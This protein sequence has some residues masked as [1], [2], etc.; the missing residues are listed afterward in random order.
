MTQPATS[1]VLLYT[2]ALFIAGAICGAATMYHLTPAA[3]PLKLGRINEIAAKLRTRLDSRLQLT[4]EQQQKF[5]PLIMQTSSNLEAIHKDCLDRITAALDQLHCQMS[6]DLTP[7]QKLLLT[8]LET[9]RRATM[10]QKYNYC[11]AETNSAA[12]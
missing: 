4:P 5:E 12:H 6:P 2:A 8:G 9:E 3:Q 7:D 11:A 10:L 1:K